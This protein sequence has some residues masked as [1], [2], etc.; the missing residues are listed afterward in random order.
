M[1]TLRFVRGRA[2]VGKTRHCLDSIREILRKEPDG[3]PLILLA[4]E[5]STFQLE[6][7]LATTPGL[8]GLIRAHVLSFRR[9]AHRL[10]DELGGRAIPPAGNLKRLLI[11]KN[12]LAS[13]Q[14]NLRYYGAS[15]QTTGFAQRVDATLTEWR[16][17][18]FTSEDA[19]RLRVQWQDSRTHAA[20][21]RKLHDLTLIEQEYRKAIADR[22]IDPED[23]LERVAG[24]AAKSSLLRDAQIWV[25][26]FADFTT[27]ER[28]ALMAILRVARSAEIALCLDPLTVDEANPLQGA[29]E[30]APRPFAACE[31]THWL[32]HREATEAGLT[33]L[34]PLELFEPHRYATAPALRALEQR[35]F[36]P[37]AGGAPL[38]TERI[39]AGPE[40][41]VVG[42]QSLHAEV[43]FVALEALRMAREENV[44]YR[45]MAIVTRDLDP[46]HDLLRAALSR[47]K[48][49]FFMDRQREVQC[50]PLAELLS[51][52]SAIVAS[53]WKTEDVVQALKTGLLPVSRDEADRL[54]NHALAFGLNNQDWLKA[55]KWRPAGVESLHS[56]ATGALEAFEKALG[57]NRWTTASVYAAALQSLMETLDAKK[58]IERW[59][60]ESA[61][62]G[63]H[64]TAA[65]HRQVPELIEGLLHEWSDALGGEKLSRRDCAELLAEGLSALR[66][67]L[68]PPTLDHLL[69]GS[70]E[71]SRHPDL[72]VVFLLGMNTGIFPKASSEDV[73]L[74][75]A[76]RA[77]LAA[78]R[79]ELAPSASERLLNEP[80]LA[81]IAM[82][83]PSERL[84]ITYSQT[85]E[86]CRLREP[87]QY[88]QRIREIIDVVP[89]DAAQ[90][91]REMQAIVDLPSL[92]A[93]VTAALGRQVRLEGEAPPFRPWPALLN[94]GRELDL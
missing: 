93:A 19:E 94:M 73:L 51:S 12:I 62:Q 56:R 24:L 25:D 39:A 74:N 45:E 44:R 27:L 34:D 69:V 1:P 11:L 77:I 49:P 26:G 38:S 85:D 20:L 50:H 75:D 6:R 42:A 87:S 9:L 17:Y 35:F 41:R 68:A 53:N 72:R 57:G 7:A 31:R 79:V 88:L 30:R 37:T 47:L 2:V 33:L 65:V 66:M 48:I 82:T 3:P 90:S 5:Q 15:A 28:R 71:R 64:E 80:Y 22:F 92:G 86:K 10:F 89:E 21:G 13:Q 55:E 32:L 14:A 81:Y 78:E 83:R 58:K 59:Q 54:E 29:S 36:R 16:R 67:R 70:V 23:Y 4:P 18:H 91:L 43:D 84:I 8:D 52:A 63:D 46:C 60:E 76:D 40:L 61:D